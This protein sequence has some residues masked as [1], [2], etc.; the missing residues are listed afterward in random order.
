MTHGHLHDY[1][2][3]IPITLEQNCIG[4]EGL[5]V[6]FYVDLEC[7]PYCL[8]RYHVKQKA[9]HERGVADLENFAFEDGQNSGAF[10]Q[11]VQYPNPRLYELIHIASSPTDET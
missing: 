3:C 5:S 6:F 9:L 7:D 4:N 2:A 11:C 10:D 8:H 1:E